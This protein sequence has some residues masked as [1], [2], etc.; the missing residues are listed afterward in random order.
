MINCARLQQLLSVP[1]LPASLCPLHHAV[2][3]GMERSEPAAQS[4]AAGSADTNPEIH[5]S[6]RDGPQRDL[7]ADRHPVYRHGGRGLPET[8]G[9]P[10][11]I[12]RDTVQRL[13]PNRAK[14]QVLTRR[15][16]EKA[17]EV[18]VRVQ[19]VQ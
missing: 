9:E 3:P 17:P 10:E 11:E 8:G 6:C 2:R 14:L 7:P 12:R 4:S 1:A 19:L 13:E 15:S 18:R 16:S 5:S